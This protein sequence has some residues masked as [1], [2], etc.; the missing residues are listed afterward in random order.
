MSLMFVDGKGNVERGSIEGFL[1]IGQFQGFITRKPL[2][3]LDRAA[4]FLNDCSQAWSAI[5]PHTHFMANIRYR[6]LPMLFPRPVPIRRKQATVVFG[7][8][9]LKRQ[10][11]LRR[12]D[13]T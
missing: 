10:C 2:A 9:G 3:S 8:T 6:T 7:I 5:V 12:I 13:L 1:G 4:A 11:R